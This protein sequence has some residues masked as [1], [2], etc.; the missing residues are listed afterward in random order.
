M[1][2][3]APQ[4]HALLGQPDP[5]RRP[6]HPHR[7]DFTHATATTLV[8]AFNAGF[9]MSDANGGYYTDNKTIIPLRTGAAS[10]VVYK[11]GS[12]DGRAMGT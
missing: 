10:F 4:G 11:D 6:L 3:E 5:R 8:A 7:A 2:T 12:F 1:D 9:L